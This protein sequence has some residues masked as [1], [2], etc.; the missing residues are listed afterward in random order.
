MF[1]EDTQFTKL[2]AVGLFVL[3]SRCQ[4]TIPVRFYGKDFSTYLET[5]EARPPTLS[6]TWRLVSFDGQEAPYGILLKDL[7][8]T[9]T[10][11]QNVSDSVHRYSGHGVINNF[12]G[13]Y[14]SDSTR[15]ISIRTMGATR[16]SVMGDLGII[17]GKFMQ[18]AK[19]AVGYEIF[20][21]TMRLYT[22]ERYLEF[23]N[24]YAD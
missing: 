7:G 5:K 11:E 3:S 10:F 21:A 16:V 20:D 18:S 23:R 9:L 14:E 4:P 15:N 8:L 2:V 6:G 24:T 12:G 22:E 13:H 19:Q 1:T 17:E